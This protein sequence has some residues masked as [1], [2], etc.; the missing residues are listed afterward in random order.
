[1]YL[2]FRLHP[3]LLRLKIPTHIEGL[4]DVALVVV[5]RNTICAIDRCAIVFVRAIDI[6]IHL[7]A[8]QFV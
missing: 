2:I 5:S 8:S 6:G 3:A 7:V 1:M 4:D